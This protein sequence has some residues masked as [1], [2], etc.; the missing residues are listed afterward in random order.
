MPLRLSHTTWDAL[1]PYAIAQ[2]WRELL[3]WRIQEP[4]TYQPGSDDCY[5]VSPHGYTV[6]FY[7][8]PDAKKTKNR[9]HMDLTPEHSTRD[10]EITR[11]QQLGASIVDD[12]RHDLGWAVLADPEGNEFCIL[13]G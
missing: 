8:V 7:R 13:D 6:L 3:D 1:D 5:L 11:A 12:R 10:H 2:F 4:D 9:A